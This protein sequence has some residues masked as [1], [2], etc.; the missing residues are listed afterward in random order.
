[1]SCE[2]L[3]KV[4][5]FL[6]GIFPKNFQ[7]NINGALHCLMGDWVFPKFVYPFSAP[8]ETLED[9][10]IKKRL[11]GLPA[12]SIQTALSY[13]LRCRNLEKVKGHPFAGGSNVIIRLESV[14]N[15]IICTPKPHPELKKYQKMYGFKTGAEVLIYQHGLAFFKE[16]ISPYVKDKVFIDA[17]ACIG[18]LIPALLEYS[19]QKIYAFEPSS[20]NAARFVKEMRKRKISSEKVEIVV[21]GLGGQEG[22][23][24]FDDRGGDGQQLLG[25]D[26][27]CRITTL[28]K[29]AS[30]QNLS[31]VG[32]I[33]ADVEGMGLELL[34]GAINTIQRDRPVLSLA[35]YHS[36]DELLGQ[37]EFLSSCLEN[38]HFE[39]RDLPPGSSFEITLLGIPR[40]VWIE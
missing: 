13:V 39:L 17:G 25:G 19:P 8:F 36:V 20:V 40:E 31:A 11:A 1:M 21:A 5:W 22:L 6:L 23:V 38:Y 26:K 35:A 15:D 14:R 27:M 29:F 37:Y 30:E 16:L 4:Y 12:D 18:E 34:R 9:E 28:D 7:Q 2:K 3:K 33:K 10:E 32:L 24:A